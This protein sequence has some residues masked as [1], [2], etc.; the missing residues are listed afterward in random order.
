MMSSKGWELGAWGV[1]GCGSG[2]GGGGWCC[3]TLF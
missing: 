1:N 2:S 3:T